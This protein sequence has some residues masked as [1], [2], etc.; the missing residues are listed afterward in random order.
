MMR[1]PT[2]LLFCLLIAASTVSLFAADESGLFPAP[3]NPETGYLEVSDIHKIF[4]VCCGNRS[5]KPVMC[6]H[7]GPGVGAYPRL[8]Q[9]F[10]PDKYFIVLHD[11]RGAGN[12]KPHG[13]L[14]ENTT[15]NL[16]EDIEKLRKHFNLGK[17]LLYGGSWGS[18]LAMA[19]AETYPENVT[20]MIMRG[21]FLGTEEEIEYHY[22]GTSFHYPE[23]HDRLLSVLPDRSKGTHPDYLFK[24]VQSGDEELAHKVLD[25][26][27]R[28]ELKFMKLN[29][30]DERI[31]MWLGSMDHDEHYRVACM[32]LTY[33]TNRYFMDENQ[34]LKNAGKLEHI[35]AILINGR[36]DM[37]SPLKAAYQVHKAM[38]KSKLVIVEEAGHSESE[39]GITKAII[40]AAAEFE[41]L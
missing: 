33:V 27:A 15:P 2:F 6:L 21:V 37:A 20:G 18:T 38:P 8:A 28:F 10:N 17:V 5:G 14:K 9:Y 7:G 31:D 4:Y 23:E 24:L 39:E 12:S 3:E 34:L 11:Q 40:E 25:A 19:Y 26:L 36:Y 13:E 22:I 41:S 32:D 16:V 30:P 1:V 35:P 29:M